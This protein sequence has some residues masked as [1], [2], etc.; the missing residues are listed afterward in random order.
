MAEEQAPRRPTRDDDRA[1]W[2]THW[3]ARR[4]PWRTEPEIDEARQRYLA[5]RRAI[6]PDVEQGIY[7][8]KDVE[9]KLTRADI[10]WLLAAQEFGGMR[11]PVDWADEHQRGRDGLD[12][13]GA[14][15]QEADLSGLPLARM[16]GGL[17]RYERERATGEQR[18]AA[19]IHL[20]RANLYDAHLE[21][22]VLSD[23]HLEGA[24]LDGTFGHRTHL[25]LAKLI[26]AHL[27]GADCSFARLDGATLI[28][29]HLE[30]ATLYRADLEWTELRK[31]Q[32]G[33]ANL[34]RAHL[35]RA[36]L[37]NASFAGKTLSTSDMGRM[38]AAGVK[39]AQAV[40]PADLREAFFD[41][42]TSL[43][44]VTLGN[45]EYGWASLAD[46]R[47]NNANL[48]V[49][50][51]TR[52]RRGMLHMRVDAIELGEERIARTATNRD[53]NPKDA[54]TRLREYQAA[55]RANRQLATVLRG[56]GL[57]EDAD[58]FAYT[59]QRLQQQ[60]LRRQGFRLATLG[61]WLLDAIAGYG[62]RPM[63]SLLAYV[64]IVVAFAVLYLLNGQ[65]AAPHL[66]WDEALVLSIS[67][68][69]GR[70]FF[71][72]GVSLGDTLARLAAGEA[73]IGLLIE[74]TFIA[75]F[76]QRFFAR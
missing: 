14:W 58:R 12:L 46:V 69:H 74:I 30:G 56:Q 36:L 73:I 51:W 72:S 16:L 38:Q 6:V 57:N 49:V 47:W 66:R 34:T 13:R 55:V 54:Q 5:E 18:A 22:A 65:F 52:P 63:R 48:A 27:E 15:L 60:A 50:D 37:D 24:T 44:G 71:T 43:N 53:G 26:E 19:A 9:P 21:D 3:A 42:A 8:F 4:M 62:Y 33:G 67:S 28:G 20:E 61:S 75:T 64:V 70:G 59:A 40:P 41:A 45:E 32:L 17:R 10:E 25:E 68:F 7:P 31:A 76:T 29:V 23:A 2:R 35:E 1:G 39:L 11:G